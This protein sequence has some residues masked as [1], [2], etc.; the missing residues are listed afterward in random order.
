MTAKDLLLKDICSRVSNGGYVKVSVDSKVGFGKDCLVVDIHNLSN[1]VET[2]DFNL[3]D[4]KIYLRS[5]QSITDK[6]VQEIRDILNSSCTGR[7]ID[8][9]NFDKFND[10]VWFTNMTI[11]ECV[12]NNMMNIVIDYLDK[13]MLDH[14]NLIKEG[15]ALEA[16]E[17]LYYN[18]SIN[19]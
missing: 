19:S 6:E 1:F 4:V 9:D 11:Y 14:R 3:D 15:L 16:P 7:K 17:D 5:M 2:T 12:S 8:K 18:C 13:R 10:I